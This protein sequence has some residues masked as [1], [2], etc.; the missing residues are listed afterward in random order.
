LGA[1]ALAKI[2]DGD[3]VWHRMGD[4]GYLDDLGRF[5]YCG[6][7]S[8]RVESPDGALY[9]EK[10][11][12]VFNQHPLVR[13]TALVGI[14][15]RPQQEPILVFEPMTVDPNALEG[16]QDSLGRRITRGAALR[17]VAAEL[18]S[19]AL[20]AGLAGKIRRFLRHDG[21]PV[22]VRHNSKINR[23]A[24]AAW[25]ECELKSSRRSD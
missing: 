3:A 25:A 18:E 4:V 19:Q 12:A 14:G 2:C 21:F 15:K 20:N 6:R 11:E 16:H 13:R 23:E 17:D 24:L 22:D 1:N 10:V 9:T 8:H 5:W 7:K